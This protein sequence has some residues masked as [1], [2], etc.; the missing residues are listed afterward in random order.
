M[1]TMMDRTPNDSPLGKDGLDRLLRQAEELWWGPEIERRQR[2]GSIDEDFTYSF[3]QALFPPDK[4]VVVR[5]NEEVR[6]MANIR[7]SRPIEKGGHVYRSDLDGLEGFDLLEEDLDCGHLTIIRIETGWFV[8]FNF[9]RSRALCTSLLRSAN[10]FLDAAQYAIE[11]HKSGPAVDNLYSACELVSKA[12]LI[13]T[14]MLDRSSKS[15]G[16][17]HSKI[18]RSR[19]LGNVNKDFVGLFNN[20]SALR[21]SCRYEG[22]TISQ[23]LLSNNDLALVRTEISRIDKLCR[24][25]PERGSG[26]PARLPSG[27]KA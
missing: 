8:S 22:A 13:L 7:A 17:I 24:Q 26:A 27:D 15:H 11:H 23:S 3:A 10:D 25:F 6:G 1:G 20:L 5:F 14:S 18:N 4:A 19:R 9:L 2:S 12:Q 16:A 21:P